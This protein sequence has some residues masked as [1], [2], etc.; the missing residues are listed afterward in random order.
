MS[1]MHIVLQEYKW[2]LREVLSPKQPHIQDDKPKL[3]PKA[4]KYIYFF[5]K[6]VPTMN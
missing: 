1:K 3:M 2:P 6:T 4:A 5:S